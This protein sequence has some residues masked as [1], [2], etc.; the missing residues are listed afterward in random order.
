MYSAE[1]N[2]DQQLSSKVATSMEEYAAGIRTPGTRTSSNGGFLFWQARQHDRAVE[3]LP[4][5]A[6]LDLHICTGSTT[7]GTGFRYGL[8]Q[9]HPMDAGT[10]SRKM[11]H[12]EQKDGGSG[13]GAGPGAGPDRQESQVKRYMRRR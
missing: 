11:R 13:V 9:P 3:A 2:L 6:R 4:G 1:K 5:P 8:L 10:G 7:T 12:R